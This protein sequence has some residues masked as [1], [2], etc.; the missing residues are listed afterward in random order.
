[1][2][3]FEYRDSA[4]WCEGVAM[5][6]IAREFGTPVYVYSARTFVE[7]YERIATAFAKLQ[8]LICYSIKSCPN[9]HLCKLLARK[10]AGFDVVSGG[11]L[12]RARRAGGDPA[13]IVFAGVGKSEAEIRAALRC[14]IGLLNVE[15]EAEMDQ[16]VRIAA[17]ESV[18]A[19]AALRINPDVDPV[20]HRHTTTGTRE[21]KFGV[22]VA[23]ARR[24]FERFGRTK[25][26]SLC[27]LH[28]H[29]GSPVNRVD[30][31]VAAIQRA[32]EL[33]D[34]L[35]RA[36]FAIDTLDIGGGFSAHYRGTEA[37]DAAAYAAAIVPL[38][39]ERGLRIILEPGRS[40]AANAGVLLTRVEYV[41]PANARRFVIVDAG[42]NDLIRPVLYDAYHFIWPVRPGEGFV[43]GARGDAI[44]APGLVETDVVG[45][46]CETG[47]FFARKRRLPPVERGELLAVF[48]AGAYG[49]SMS[50][51][52]NS[53]PRAA[54]VLVEG[55]AARLI[56]RR[57]TYDDL[58]EA[59]HV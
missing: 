4:L 29:I 19:R 1:M 50:S 47:D 31:Y 27:G 5:E 38:L 8:P 21:T 54:E 59:E 14:G 11:E 49:M 12:F 43:P 30:P 3:Y 57:E 10:G 32:L 18:S 17:E 44:D 56:R 40:I 37:P 58:V 39:R 24:F 55:D 2:D 16:L 22:D 42:M 48:T 51:Q 52:Y 15:S 23:R 7:H 9:T 34:E 36:G 53:R 20:T 13:K 28:L 6:R 46:V 26:V 41:K 35:T 33:I 45:P 25:E